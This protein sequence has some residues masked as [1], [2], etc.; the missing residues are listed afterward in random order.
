[1]KWRG[2]LVIIVSN[3]K[4]MCRIDKIGQ[5]HLF[6]RRA[7]TRIDLVPGATHKT[8]IRDSAGILRPVYTIIHSN[9]ALDA[10]ND[11]NQRDV[12]CRKRQP[13]SAVSSALGIDK[14]GPQQQL[15]KPWQRLAD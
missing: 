5:T 6:Q 14:A 10:L 13:I 3:W 15:G 1:M 7:N 12:F 9:R 8:A 2:H 11:P 4:Q